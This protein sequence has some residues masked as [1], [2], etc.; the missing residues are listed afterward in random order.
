MNAGALRA[1]EFDQIVDAVARLAQTPP[2]VGRLA[3]LQPSH[4]ADEVSA[5]L[6]H[7]AETARFLS[8]SGEIALRAPAELD[9][10]LAALTV[11]GRALESLH[12]VGLS[13]FLS[14]IDSTVSGI[15]RQ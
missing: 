2:G 11:E 9:D 8:G 6:A 15:R 12:L 3:R 13:T 5:A 1:L 4:D 10:I 7:T 14:S